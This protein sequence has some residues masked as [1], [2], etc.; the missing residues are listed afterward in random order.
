MLAMTDAGLLVLSLREASR[1]GNP[2]LA[3]TAK[4]RRLTLDYFALLAMTDAG[5]LV[6]SL[7]E[8]SRRGN[9][10]LAATAKFRR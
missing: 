3:A 2:W 4:F 9:P 6:L 8:A 7:R 1:R 10:R 5:L